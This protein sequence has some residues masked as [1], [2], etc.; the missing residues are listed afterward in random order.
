MYFS[1]ARLELRSLV[2]QQAELRH[3]AEPMSPRV[4]VAQLRLQHI[5]GEL[6]GEVEVDRQ[7]TAQ[8]VLLQLQEQLVPG[9]LF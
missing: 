4:V 7:P 2:R 9:N 5:C 8:H 3:V 6:S 1:G